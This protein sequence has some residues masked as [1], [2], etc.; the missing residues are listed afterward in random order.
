MAKPTEQL[1]LYPTADS[2]EQVVQ[3][4]L[5]KLPIENP[6]ELVALLQLHSNTIIN[7]MRIPT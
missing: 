4:G 2:V 3:E 1:S 5:A 6:N 7:L